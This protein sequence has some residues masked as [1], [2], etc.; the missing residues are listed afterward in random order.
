MGDGVTT[1]HALVR[2]EIKELV[3]LP[4]V[5]T[6]PNRST[7]DLNIDKVV[8]REGVAGR[9]A[10]RGRPKMVGDADPAKW[11]YTEHTRAK[12]ELLEKYLGVWIGILGSRN[13]KLLIVDGFAGKGEYDTGEV[14]SPVI[15]HRK[16]SEL[17]KAGRVDEVICVFV[18]DNK[19]NYQDLQGVLAKLP[20]TPGIKIISPR[21]A[22]FESVVEELFTT[23]PDGIGVP[24]FWFIDPFGYS[25]FSFETIAKIMSLN[26]SEIFVNFMVSFL[27]RFLDHPDLDGTND[28]LFGTMKW[29][30]IVQ[31]NASGVAKGPTQHRGTNRKH[32]SRIVSAG[33]R[34][35]PP[36]RSC[37]RLT[38][39][40]TMGGCRRVW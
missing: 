11:Q 22:D 9:R 14:G 36:T 1:I 35:E 34:G 13:R 30:E 18:E 28:R 5:T 23:A 31:R 17:I 21:P 2:R 15:I 32:Y 6:G 25:D 12:H 24:S 33:Q 4:R 26:R 19:D 37:V 3:F 7:V 27:Q 40:C 8:K 38:G 20:S 10:I 16:A 39:V 29:R